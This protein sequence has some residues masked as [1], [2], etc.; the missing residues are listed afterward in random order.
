MIELSASLNNIIQEARKASPYDLEQYLKS[1]KIPFNYGLLLTIEDPI[2]FCYIL[3]VSVKETHKQTLNS[4]EFSSKYL[5][6]R[7]KICDDAETL[8]EWISKRASN[9]NSLKI[10]V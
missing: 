2:T 5:E 1:I 9:R 10:T 7:N 6:S 3:S 8:S 4:A